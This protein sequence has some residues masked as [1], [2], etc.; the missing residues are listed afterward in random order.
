MCNQSAAAAEL[1]EAGAG[2]RGHRGPPHLPQDFPR[3]AAGLEILGHW[4][5]VQGGLVAGVRQELCKGGLVA[6]LFR[7]AP[8]GLGRRHHRLVRRL[9]EVSRSNIKQLLEPVIR[10]SSGQL[11]SNFYLVRKGLRD[12]PRAPCLL[13]LAKHLDPISDSPGRAR[14][15]WAAGLPPAN[16][17]RAHRH[18]LCSHLPGAELRLTGDPKGHLKEGRRRSQLHKLHLSS[19]PALTGI[20]VHLHLI[21]EREDLWPGPRGGGGGGGGG[22]AGGPGLRGAHGERAHRVACCELGGA[23]GRRPARVSVCA[24]TLHGIHG[25]SG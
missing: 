13:G 22:G 9:S 10:A 16:V 6:G 11:I 20:A 5:R 8:H 19:A 15:L 14:L 18:L 7:L 17:L 12:A 2:R 1:L 23:H 25:H 24:S 21:P 4:V 3:Q